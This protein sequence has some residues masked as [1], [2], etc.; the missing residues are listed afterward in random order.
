MPPALTVADGDEHG[1]IARMTSIRTTREPCAIVGQCNLRHDRKGNI[2][3]SFHHQAIMT[4]ISITP[5]PQALPPCN[6]LLH[7]FNVLFVDRA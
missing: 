7:L 5:Q 1:I 2:K 4:Y 6:D 3:H